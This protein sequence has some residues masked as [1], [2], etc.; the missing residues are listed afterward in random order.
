[1]TDEQVPRTPG[2]MC[3]DDVSR[4]LGRSKNPDIGI[5]ALA[6]AQGTSFGV[7][8]PL[9]RTTRQST[10]EPLLRPAG[11]TV[12]LLLIVGPLLQQPSRARREV[13]RYQPATA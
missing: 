2:V 3:G 12:C 11:P 4:R 10:G 9:L 7:C 6:E 1:M 5:R 13:G 8:E